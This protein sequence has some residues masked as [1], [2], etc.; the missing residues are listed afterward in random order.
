RE[1]LSSVITALY[2]TVIFYSESYSLVKTIF[3]KIRGVARIFHGLFPV[4]QILRLFTG[5]FR[6][7]IIRKR[8]KRGACH[9]KAVKNSRKDHY[10]KV[11][12][13]CQE[14][15]PG[16]EPKKLQYRE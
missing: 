8:L 15:I 14:K 12:E 3:L 10:F 6:G 7:K 13:T 16:K 1:R 2:N 5:I 9:H 4:K 11:T